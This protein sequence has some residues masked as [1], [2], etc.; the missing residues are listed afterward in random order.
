M[1]SSVGASKV[2]QV[3]IDARL[4][5]AGSNTF[6]RVYGKVA[7]DS[8]DH[9]LRPIVRAFAQ[10]NRSRD[11]L[12]DRILVS[13]AKSTGGNSA[14]AKLRFICA[15]AC[16]QLVSWPRQCNM[17]LDGNCALNRAITAAGKRADLFETVTLPIK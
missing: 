11:L 15:A 14:N 5:V 2:D 1:Q 3:A 16:G 13:N 12:P 6:R 17:Q 10:G 9:S 7:R 8:L 4:G